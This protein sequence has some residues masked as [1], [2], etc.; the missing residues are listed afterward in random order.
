MRTAHMEWASNIGQGAPEGKPAHREPRPG[1][2][3][4]APRVGP[5]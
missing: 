5:I 1:P 4:T 2:Q 3:L